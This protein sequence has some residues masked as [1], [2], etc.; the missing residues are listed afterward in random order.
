MQVLK[1]NNYYSQNNLSF[2]AMKPNQF[3]G[4]DYAVVR[5]F[6]APVEKFRCM[7]DFQNWAQIL[8]KLNY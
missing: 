6:K 5:K 8:L 3:K 7:Q 1:I 4:L 2:E